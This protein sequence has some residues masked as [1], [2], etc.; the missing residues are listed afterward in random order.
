[1]RYQL[2]PVKNVLMLHSAMEALRE[3]S[4]GVPGLGLIF[5]RSGAGKT[6]ALASMVAKTGAVYV[7]AYA[8]ITLSALLDLLCFEL[9]VEGRLGK[10]SE[11]FK[12]ICGALQA[13]PR[14]IFVDEGDYLLHDRRMLEILR[15]IHDTEGVPV[16][17]VGM[18][19]IERKL[20]NQPQFAR[21]ISQRIEFQ[22]C[23]LEDARLVADTL[24]EVHVEEDLLRLMHKR[25]QGCIGHMV[26]ALA[27]FE[28]FAK[29]NRYTTLTAA[30]WGDRTMFLGSDRAVS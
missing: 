13:Y 15:D 27:Q 24:C 16:L 10:N 28:A 3:R 29:G 26:V 11:K 6:T 4:E 12:L 9:Q 8:A 23:D 14:P 17:L 7:R 1:M 20:V 21:R 2:V 22:A 5:G 30:Q 25:A 19:G 18:A